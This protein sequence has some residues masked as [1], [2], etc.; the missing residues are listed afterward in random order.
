MSGNVG[1]GTTAPVSGLQVVTA[2]ADTPTSQGVHL[3]KSGDYAAMQLYGSSGGFIDFSDGSEEDADFRIIERSGRLDIGAT[4]TSNGMS[5]SSSG[6]V[7]IGTTVPGTRLEIY[8]DNTAT[9]G[10]RINRGSVDSTNWLDIYES[11]A[12]AFISNSRTGSLLSNGLSTVFQNVGSDGTRVNMYIEGM[13]GNVGIGTAS[14]AYKLD[15]SGDIRATGT[16]YGASGTQV[17]VGTGTENY[18]SK[19]SA[20]GTLGNSVIYDNGS[21]VG[22]GTTGPSGKLTVNLDNAN[23]DLNSHTTGHLVLDNPNSSGQSKLIF[24][25]NGTNLGGVR[26]DMQGNFNWHA[27]D[28]QGHMFYNSLDTSVPSMNIAS[29]GVL[30]GGTAGQNAVNKLDVKGNAAIGSTYARTAAPSNGLII[31]G[32]VGIGTTSPGAKLDIKTADSSGATYFI[33]GETIRYLSI[34]TSDV[35]ASAGAQ[36][37]FNIA[38]VS[39]QYKFSNNGGDLLLIDSS[40]NVGIGTTSP[41]YKLDVVGGPIRVNYGMY[42]NANNAGLWLNS[43]GTTYQ[44]G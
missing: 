42:I 15:V 25:I 37:N 38:S 8:G 11:N 31:E 36:H 27:L 40:G 41:A 29:E 21:N 20:S 16:I 43:N 14:P 9:G 13:S 10:L 3:G 30:I 2:I 17:P 7:G 34:N 28:V 19:W 22:I 6:N 24:R 32:N 5:I 39:G 44:N 35:G 18:L 23:S 33:G 4:P 26:S 12:K 1:I